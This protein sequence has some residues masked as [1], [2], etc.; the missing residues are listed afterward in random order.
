MAQKIV[1]YLIV[2][3]GCL[4][5]LQHRNRDVFACFSAKSLNNYLI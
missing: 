3:T 4:P 5:F 2:A 1:R